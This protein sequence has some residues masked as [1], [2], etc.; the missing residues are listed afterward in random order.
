[1]NLNL[2]KTLADGYKSNS[3]IARVLTEGWV[4]EN[5]YCSS[6]GNNRLTGFQKNAPV[7]D[8]FCPSCKSQ[9][10]LKSKKDVLTLKIVDGAYVTMIDRINSEDNPHFFFLNYSKSQLRV[11]N[12]LVIPKYYFVDDIIEKRK[13]L[14]KNARR[15][16]WVGCNILL[17]NIPDYGKIFYIKDGRE[18][19]KKDVLNSW[20]KTS[21]LSQQKKE[22]R[23]WLIEIMRIIDKIP[24]SK[25]KL[26]DVYK[27]ENELHYKFPNNNFIKDKIR[28]Q[29]QVMRDK[30]LIEFR[31][32][33][34]Y[35]KV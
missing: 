18:I 30:G 31:E 12:F 4:S 27:F 11:H 2:N 20:M 6:C 13:P 10:E 9:Y 23:G 32:R 1:M 29:L 34:N 17:R 26:D 15:S 7:A 21:F 28:Q 3:Q 33:G 35:S 22:N 25:F 5:V 24:D 16:G 19:D 14:S 8:F